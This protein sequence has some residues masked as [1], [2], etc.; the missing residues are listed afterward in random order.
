MA[1]KTCQITVKPDRIVL[2]A[3]ANYLEKKTVEKKAKGSFSKGI[4]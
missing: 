2:V 1:A 3:V 4:I